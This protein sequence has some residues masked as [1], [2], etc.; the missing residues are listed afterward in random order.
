MG[1]HFV[2]GRPKPVT[3]R[4]SGSWQARGSWKAPCS[5]RTCSPAMNRSAGG[6]PASSWNCKGQGRQLAGEPPALLPSGSWRAPRAF[7]ATWALSR[8][9]FGI[10]KTVVE[11][12]GRNRSQR[13]GRRGKALSLPPGRKKEAG[14]YSGLFKTTHVKFSGWTTAS[15]WLKHTTGDFSRM[16]PVVGT[17]RENDE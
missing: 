14:H 17:G 12:H 1:T 9:P 16:S 4:R 11:T 3:D 13:E 15:N 10:Q 7:E 6:S 5:F 8:N 2:T